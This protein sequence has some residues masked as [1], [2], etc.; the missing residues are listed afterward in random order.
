MTE[1]D[2]IQDELS[3]TD[4]SINMYLLHPEE[5]SPFD[6]EGFMFDSLYAL[7]M[8]LQSTKGFEH[9]YFTRVVYMPQS[10]SYTENAED[11][12]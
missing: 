12:L 6:D 3:N 1:V 4:N 11:I 10:I 2:K 9:Y 7:K 5:D 8:F